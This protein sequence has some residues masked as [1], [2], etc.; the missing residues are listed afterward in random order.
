MSSTFPRES[1]KVFEGLD[2]SPET[3]EELITNIRRRLTPHALKIRADIEVNCFGYEGIEAIKQAL[4]AGEACKTETADVKIKV[5]QDYLKY[6]SHR[7][8]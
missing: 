4:F 8:V 5:G 7:A 2:I 3:K 1:D 6:Y